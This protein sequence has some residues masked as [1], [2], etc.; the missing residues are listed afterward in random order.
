M[1]CPNCGHVVMSS[2]Q[3]L[4]AYRRTHGLCLHCGVKKIGDDVGFAR[5]KACR[6]QVL[7]WQRMRKV[8]EGLSE[9]R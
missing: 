2:I 6:V 5:C 9:A 4:R 1:N 8:R 3:K 7:K